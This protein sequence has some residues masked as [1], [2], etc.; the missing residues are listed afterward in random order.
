MVGFRQWPA[1][2]DKGKR[3][4]GRKRG[5]RRRNC[6]RSKSSARLTESDSMRTFI[7]KVMTRL[8]MIESTESWRRRKKNKQS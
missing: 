8:L 1:A 7:S 5:E 2:E 6:H 3:R 4:G